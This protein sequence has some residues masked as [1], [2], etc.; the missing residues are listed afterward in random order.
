MADAPAYSNQTDLNSGSTSWFQSFEDWITPDFVKLGN[1]D[2]SV[3]T[4]TDLSNGSNSTV[5]GRP[6][7][8]GGLP[9]SGTINGQPGFFDTISNGIGKLLGTPDKAVGA[10]QTAAVGGEVV[11]GIAVVAAAVVAVVYFSKGGKLPTLAF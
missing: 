6:P 10:V 1:G 7:S 2:T 5:N 3:L 9:Q 11:I 8:D 4:P